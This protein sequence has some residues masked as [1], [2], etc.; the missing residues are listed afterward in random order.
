[1]SQPLS[2]Q[3]RWTIAYALALIAVAWVAVE[4]YPQICIGLFSDKATCQIER[5]YQGQLER[6]AKQS[7]K[8]CQSVQDSSGE[9]A[10]YYACTEAVRNACM[11]K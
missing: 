1:M 10:A 6:C 4:I 11:A 8:N 7:W 5:E 9:S 2:K 3:Q